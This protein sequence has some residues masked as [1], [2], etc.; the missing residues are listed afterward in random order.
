MEKKDEKELGVKGV[1]GLVVHNGKIVL[2]MQGPER[3]YKLA[4]GENGC[5]IKTLGGGLE[6]EDENNSRN[7]LFREVFE[8]VKEISEKDLRIT[9]NPIFSKSIRMKDLNPFEKNSDLNMSA[10]FYIMEIQKKDSISPNDLPALIEIPFEKFESM[11]FGETKRLSS[12]SEYVIKNKKATCE[13]PEVYS[14]FIPEEVREYVGILK[15][16]VRK[17]E[18]SEMER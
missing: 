16:S 12:I 17:V 7:A 10:D 8:E 15:N 9:K 2:G 6:K 11:Q 3:W 1:E 13:L 18:G 14:F 4:N 5:I